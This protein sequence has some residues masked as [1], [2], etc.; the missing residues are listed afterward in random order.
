MMH[1]KKLQTSLRQRG[2]TL[3]EIAIVLVIVGLLLGGLLMPLSTQVKMQKINETQKAMEEI[4]EAIIG[5]AMVNGFLPCPDSLLNDGVSDTVPGPTPTC[6]SDV[7]ILPW[8]T[9]NVKGT[10]SWGNRYRYQVSPGFS[11]PALVTPCS[12]TD[13]YIGLCDAGNITV[14]TRNPTTKAPQNIAVNVPAV[15]LSYGPNGY[16]GISE[17]GAAQAPPPA[18]VNIDEINNSALG[19]VANY[20][21]RPRTDQGTS[22]VCSDTAGG[23]PFCEF[24]DVVTWITPGILFSR[25]L[26]AGRL[27]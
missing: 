2:F 7:G 3:V 13:V 8:V 14:R 21:S 5:F 23:S 15:I 16:G 9:L 25:M 1:H 12:N 22:G 24:D 19:V 11:V 27:P 4:K 10:D 26:A 18:G 6:S 17:A 20:I